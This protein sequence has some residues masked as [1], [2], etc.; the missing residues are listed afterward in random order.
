MEALEA[1]ILQGLGYPDP[2]VTEKGAP[3][4]N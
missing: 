2:Y 1:A 4:E 3:D